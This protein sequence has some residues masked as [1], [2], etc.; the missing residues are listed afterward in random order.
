MREQL[1]QALEILLQQNQLQ[2]SISEQ[3]CQIEI[4]AAEFEKE[5]NLGLIDLLYETQGGMI[6]N[7]VQGGESSIE[8]KYY[9]DLMEQSCSHETLVVKGTQHLNYNLLVEKDR[10]TQLQASQ[11]PQT[12]QPGKRKP[13]SGAVSQASQNQQTLHNLQQQ[14]ESVIDLSQVY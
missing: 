6:F 2:S 12:A 3:R 9:R 1:E 7:E 10:T 4:K 5:I 8:F 11:T 13:A 14:Y